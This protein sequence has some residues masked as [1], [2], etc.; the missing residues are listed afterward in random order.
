MVRAASD[1]R[2]GVEWR[3]VP[4]PPDPDAPT[5]V[6]VAV[7]A[8]DVDA[9][10]RLADRLALP[11]RAP[12]AGEMALAWTAGGLVLR[13]TAEAGGAA[14]RADF[15]PARTGRGRDPLLRAIGLGR[16]PGARVIDATGGLGQDTWVLAAAG[17]LVTVIE[18]NPVVAAL[19]AD[20][21]ERATASP[22]HRLVAARIELRVGDARSLLAAVDPPAEVVYLD[23][24]YP[25]RDKRALKTKTMR[26]FRRLVG[27]DE[28]AAAL[29]A[30]ALRAA[31]RRVVV[32]RPRRAPP[33]A[34]PTPSGALTGRTTR[35]DLYP[36]A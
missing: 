6:V 2:R 12:Q 4:G 29:L 25:E 21:L 1:N 17:A 36:P 9:A 20:G 30:A 24:M 10:G 23:P 7:D 34:G 35:F 19:L 13:D 3:C 32:K 11:L 22:E 31:T 18:R 33:L 26:L 14:V 5:P 16:W 27:P 15:P 28:D 8:V